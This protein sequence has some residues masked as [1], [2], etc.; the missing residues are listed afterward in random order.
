[1]MYEFIEELRFELCKKDVNDMEDVLSYFE[2]MIKDRMENGEEIEDIL[3]DLGDPKRIADTLFGDQVEGKVPEKKAET[4]AQTASFTGV[5]KIE[6]E[7]VSYNIDFRLTDGEEVTLEYESDEFSTLKYSLHHEKLHI[8]QEYAYN[9]LDSLRAL[10]SRFSSKGKKRPYHAT[11]CIP[12]DIDLDIEIDNVSGDLC[13]SG[14]RCGKLDIETV[15]GDLRF[16][17]CAFDEADFENVSGDVRIADTVFENEISIDNVSGDLQMERCG[18]PS[19]DIDTV[20][21]NVDLL[22]N[23]KRSN[24][25]VSISGLH[26]NTKYKTDGS[27]TLKVDTVSGKVNCSFIDD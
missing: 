20:S 15:S 4:P 7:T 9:G 1:M 14:L 23:E 13:F 2:E 10:F 27:A 26:K 19:I 22:L 5:K 18:C 11:L 16:D 8:E 12:A 21:G 17:A 25:S 6:T 24:T 3:A